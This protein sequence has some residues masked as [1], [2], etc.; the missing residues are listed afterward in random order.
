MKK[1]I[2]ILGVAAIATATYAAVT[3]IKETGMGLYIGTAAGQKIGFYGTTPVAQQTTVA[4]I[5]NGTSLADLIT[6][7]NG[8]RSNLVATG[9]VK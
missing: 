3:Q 6:A 5:T 7:V 9:I 2:I 1:Y 8:I 4:A